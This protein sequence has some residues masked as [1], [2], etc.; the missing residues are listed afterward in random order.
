MV[1]IL[2]FSDSLCYNLP[3]SNT[4]KR[5]YHIESFP[6]RLVA[7]VIESE[8]K[9]SCESLSYF[10]KEDNYDVVVICFGINDL[11]HGLAM[12]SVIQNLLYLHQICRQHQIKRIIV[13]Y[14]NAEY[15]MEFNQMYS[16]Q[17]AEDIE[18][19]EFFLNLKPGDLSNDGLHLSNKGKQRLV[20][21]LCRMIPA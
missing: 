8:K 12:P 2:I 16:L 14:L 7:E 15:Y 13:M 18:F 21:D 17:S 5:Q 10:L 20:N 3:I 1:N 11:G 19:C 4:S 9:K 6:G